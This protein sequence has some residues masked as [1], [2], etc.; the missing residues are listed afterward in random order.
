[1]AKTTASSKPSVCANCASTALDRRIATYPVH[2]SEPPALAGREIHVGRVALY[3]CSACGHLMPTAAG[4][5]KV[6][7]CV[8]MSMRVFLVDLP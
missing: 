8:A 3:E 2:L 5:A 1:M 6:E 7:R 4:W